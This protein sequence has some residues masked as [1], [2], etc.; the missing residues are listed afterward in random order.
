MEQ[1]TLGF[2]LLEDDK[3]PVVFQ[4]FVFLQAWGDGKLFFSK[5][6]ELRMNQSHLNRERDSES[7]F[8]YVGSMIPKNL[9]QTKS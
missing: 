3:P 2:E 8:Y 4:D 9:L 5:G 1:L 7:C 6:E